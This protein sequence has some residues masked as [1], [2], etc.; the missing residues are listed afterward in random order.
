MP[1]NRAN[2]EPF[3]TEQGVWEFVQDNPA[4]EQSFGELQ[5]KTRAIPITDEGGFELVGTFPYG[6]PMQVSPSGRIERKESAIDQGTREEDNQQAP[7]ATKRA[8]VT[9][10]GLALSTLIPDIAGDS[11]VGDE[12]K[13]TVTVLGGEG[14]PIAQ[15]EGDP[16]EGLVNMEPDPRESVGCDCTCHTDDETSSVVA[17]A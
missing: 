15:P 8:S 16:V 9:P 7:S 3:T 6:R 1:P 17:V 14:H 11:T 10:E 4:V 13:N 12:I 5:K 2:A